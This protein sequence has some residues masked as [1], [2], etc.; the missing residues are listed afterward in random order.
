MPYRAFAR[1]EVPIRRKKERAVAVSPLGLLAVLSAVVCLLSLFGMLGRWFWVFDLASHFRMQF[2][3]VLLV[4]ALVFAGFRRWASAGLAAS[5][6][7]LN[8]VLVTLAWLQMLGE[9]LPQTR[10]APKLKLL[11]AVVD[12]VNHRDDAF[13]DLLRREDPDLLIVEDV[14]E[15]WA[16]RLVELTRERLPFREIVPRSDGFGIAWFSRTPPSVQAVKTHGPASVPS[17]RVQVELGARRLLVVGAHASPPS[18][19]DA[20]RAR[21]AQ[22]DEMATELKAFS[23]PRVLTGDLSTTPWSYSFAQLRQAGMYDSRK[24]FAWQATW[25]AGWPS[26][27]RIPLDHVLLTS[28]L[29]VLRR[30]IG[31]SIGSDHLPVITELMLR[32]D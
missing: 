10:E 8:F 18:G 32:L 5:F 6:G 16:P 17:I 22:L 21:D 9:T 1:R 20:T 30:E 26:I 4:F 27:F 24:L 25:P 19:G 28:D 13:A 15:W 31:P 7:A 2:A 29:H 3:G 23:G 14:D 12:S 11:T